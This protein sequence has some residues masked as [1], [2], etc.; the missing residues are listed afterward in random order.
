MEENHLDITDSEVLPQQWKDENCSNVDDKKSHRCDECASTLTTASNLKSHK[1]KF[2]GGY[3]RFKCST[4]GYMAYTKCTLKMHLRIHTK[5]Y[6]YKCKSCGYESKWSGHM[7]KH[8]SGHFRIKCDDCES[9]FTK[10]SSLKKHKQTAHANRF[11]C[12]TCGFMACTELKLKKHLVVHTENVRYNCNICDYSSKHS[13]HILR[14]QI[15]HGKVKIHK[16]D[17]CEAT[18]STASTLKRH[19]LTVH[20]GGIRFDCSV[21]GYIPFSKSSLTRHVLVHPPETPTCSF[22]E[23]FS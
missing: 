13:G 5:E 21:C 22:F 19:K 11:Q 10:M 9:T 23:M 8:V 6:P 18:L 7:K 20:K 17:E 12:S 3:R 1:L 4:C 15:A 16:C 2:H 14:H